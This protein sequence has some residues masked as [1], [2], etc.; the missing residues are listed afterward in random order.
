MSVV[1]TKIKRIL[2]EKN[3]NIYQ[4]HKIMDFSEGALRLMIKEQCP[5]SEKAI[6][7]LLPILE[8]SKEEFE[9]WILADKYSKELVELAIKEKKDFPYKRKSMLTTKIDALLE[10]RNMSRTDL[11]KEIKYSQSGLNRMITRQISMSEPVLIRIA[12]FFEIPQDEI[13]S[14]IVADRHKLE[15]LEQVLRLKEDL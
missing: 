9:T 10:E 11:S 14:W 6:K 15:V 12:E 5:F 13:R 8:V 1:T 3:L 7:K 4:L 2:N